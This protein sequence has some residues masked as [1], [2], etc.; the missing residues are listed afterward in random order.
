MKAEEVAAGQLFDSGQQLRV[1]IWQRRYTW[2]KQDWSELWSDI[3]HL[4]E[5]P[6]STHFI[7]EHRS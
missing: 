4:R 3:E 1:P 5:A 2:D 7:G 6:T